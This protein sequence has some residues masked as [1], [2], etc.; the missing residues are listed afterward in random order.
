MVFYKSMMIERIKKEGRFEL[1]TPDITEIMDDL[2]GHEATENC[3]LR[4]VQGEPVLYVVGE[5]GN[6]AY[7]NELDCK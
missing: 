1:I 4:R 2:D 5:S 3:W 7:V 6:G